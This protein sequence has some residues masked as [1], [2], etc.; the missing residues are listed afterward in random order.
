MQTSLVLVRGARRAFSLVEMMV[1]L[2][3]LAVVLAI[4]VPALSS[5]RNTARKAATNAMMNQLAT[6]CAQFQMDVRRLPGYFT[7]RDL[8]AAENGDRGFT[9]MHNIMV[10]LAGGVV[11]TNTTPTTIDVGPLAGQTI[12]IDTALIGSSRQ[13][14]GVT[15]KAYFQ[16]DPKFFGVV[17][18]KVANVENAQIPDLFDSWGTP[19]LAWQQDDVPNT[20]GDFVQANATNPAKFYWVQNAAHL[21]S[22]SLGK[23]AVNQGIESIIGSP[24]ASP[25]G[26]RLDSLR[27][28]LG[29]PSF[30]SEANATIPSVARA[31]I[32]FQSAGYNSTYCGRSERGG[33]LADSNGGVIAYSTTTDA[34]DAFDDFLAKVSN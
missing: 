26:T 6:A 20:T 24:N 28:L 22:A 15:N 7:P 5:A 21:R 17:S 30:P 25:G 31:P 33:K 19:I 13:I 32:I 23:F 14:K 34:I 2:L 9:T 11:Q 10:D 18:G 12:L 3:I 8:G 27:A 16:P 1:V 29:N 4:V